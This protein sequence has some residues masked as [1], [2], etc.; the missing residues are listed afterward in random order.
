MTIS[1]SAALPARS[2]M[3]LMVHSTCRA[4]PSTPASEFATARPRSSW[5]WTENTALSE[6]GTRSRTVPEHGAVLVRR[7]V[8][9]RVGQVDRGGA[10]PDRRLDAAAEVVDRGAGRI[11]RRPFD[12]VDEVARLGHGRRDD[13]EHLLLGL[14]HLV[15]EMDRRGRDE[16]V[17]A[18]LARARAPLRRPG[19]C[20]RRWR[21]RDRRRWR[22]SSRSAISRDGLEIAVRGDREAGLDDVDAHRVEKLGDLEL[23][24]ERHG[25]AWALLAVAQGGVE[26][27][28]AVG[29][30]GHGGVDPSGAAPA[31][32][33]RSRFDPAANP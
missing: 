26:D 14:A 25:G 3:P 22:S 4:P 21:G 28:D 19:R 33:P 11:H 7:R 1:S 2:P 13:F 23:L 17:D 27:Q 6:S 20:R 5:Q 15:R 9:D 30:G 29:W 8:A 18:G 10:G 32:R 31:R 12:V 16:G 24:L